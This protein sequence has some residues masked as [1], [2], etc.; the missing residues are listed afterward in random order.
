[1]QGFRFL[2]AYLDVTQLGIGFRLHQD[3]SYGG[4]IDKKIDQCAH[5][6]ISMLIFVAQVGFEPGLVTETHDMGLGFQ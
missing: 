4:G 5:F 3:G 2:L 1:M 6:H